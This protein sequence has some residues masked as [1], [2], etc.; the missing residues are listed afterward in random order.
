MCLHIYSYQFVVSCCTITF[1]VARVDKV[2]PCV[3]GIH[4]H[5]CK[6]TYTNTHTH[7]NPDTNTPLSVCIFNFFYK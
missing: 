7:T 5:S 2:L 4:L 3:A 1:C 6:Y